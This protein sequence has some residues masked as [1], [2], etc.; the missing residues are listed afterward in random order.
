MFGYENWCS[1]VFG[2]GTGWC[3]YDWWALCFF[4]MMLMM[5]LCFFFMMYMMRQRK[6]NMMCCLPLFRKAEGK[7]YSASGSA[8]DILDKRYATSEISVAEYE[9][10]KRNLNQT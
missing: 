4:V 9:E 6:G 1:N 2:C 5:G 7:D 3:T 10:K 8:R